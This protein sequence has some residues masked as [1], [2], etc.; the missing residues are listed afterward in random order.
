MSLQSFLDLCKKTPGIIDVKSENITDSMLAQIRSKKYNFTQ[1]PTLFKFTIQNATINLIIPYE[2]WSD[3]KDIPTNHLLDLLN[4]IEDTHT[5]CV[6]KNCLI[7]S[8]DD[9]VYFLRPDTMK[10]YCLIGCSIDAME[11]VPS[12]VNKLINLL[13][14]IP[15]IKNPI[16]YDVVDDVILSLANTNTAIFIISDV[17]GSTEKTETMIPDFVYGTEESHINVYNHVKSN[18]EELLK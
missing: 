15:K 18:V 2:V 7:Y 8:K 16:A 1:K 12:S 11:N 6:D 10:T 13:K 4:R 17:E 3:L 14:T 9:A 5:K